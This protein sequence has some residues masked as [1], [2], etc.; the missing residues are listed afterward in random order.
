MHYVLLA[1]VA[2]RL[3]ASLPAQGQAVPNAPVV[4][5]A[6]WL[7]SVQRLPLAQ[8]V[9]AVQQ[10]A[11]RDTLLAPYQTPICY[12]YKGASPAT[13]S[14]P[15]A[16]AVPVSSKPRVYPLI[17]VVDGQVFSQNDAA[18]IRRFQQALLSRP[19]KQVTLLYGMGAVIYGTRGAN[20]VVILSSRK[21]RR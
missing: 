5:N 11:R 17:Y 3:L 12:M 14:A 20:G 19:I 13:R 18:T 8:Q 7:D 10:R 15:V 9:A 6:A 4:S 2:F 21:R 1:L 16:A